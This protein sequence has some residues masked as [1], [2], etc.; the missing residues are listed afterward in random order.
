MGPWFGSYHITGVPHHGQCSAGARVSKPTM[1]AYI[2][3]LGEEPSSGS[4]RGGVESSGDD[5]G[6]GRRPPRPSQQSVRD[7][8][9][10]RETSPGTGI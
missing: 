6:I 10:H 9:L 1:N 2:S 7:R 4:G 8:P 3:Q 5:V